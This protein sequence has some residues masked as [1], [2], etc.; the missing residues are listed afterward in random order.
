MEATTDYSA[1]VQL[2][3]CL[4]ALALC[5]TPQS[6]SAGHASRYLSFAVGHIAV[7][8]GEIDDPLVYKLEYR[9]RPGTRWQLAP[10]IGAARS[11]NGSTFVFA[12]LAR[13]FQLA[14]RWVLTP[15]F[16]LGVFNDGRDI[17]LGHDLEFRSGI[18]LG[19]EF[20]NHMRLAVEFFHLSNGGLGDLNPG[21]EPLF[22]A[23]FMPL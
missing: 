5:L 2:T 14:G 18:R 7:L 6:V 17:K 16:G 22:L 1:R 19:Y 4:I 23:W 8:D 10:S 3:H 13:D 21:A 15:S 20:H 9:F 12:D 11:E